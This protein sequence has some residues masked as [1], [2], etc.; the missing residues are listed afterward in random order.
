M[1]GFLVEYNRRTGDWKVTE[2]PGPDGHRDALLRRLE[3]DK[4]RTDKSWEYVSL[5]SDS[6]KTIKK[7][8]SRYFHGRQ[9]QTAE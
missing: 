8:H 9:V 3:L 7:T 1:P 6:L 4:A 2:F 5:S